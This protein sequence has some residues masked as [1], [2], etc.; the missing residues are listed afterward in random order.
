MGNHEFYHGVAD[1]SQP[2]YKKEITQN[3]FLLNNQ[4]HIE[5]NIRFI[6][7]TLWSHIPDESSAF[8]ASRLNDYHFN[9]S[10]S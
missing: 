3:H 9:I 4:V 10:A 5:K 8:I 6:I 7:S 1:Y 2:E